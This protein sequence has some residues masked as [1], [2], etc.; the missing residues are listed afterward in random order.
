MQDYQTHYESLQAARQWGFNISNF[1]ALCKTT[2][3]IF[4]FIDYWDVKRHEL[5]FAIDGIVLKVNSYAQQQ[6]LGFT[7]KSPKWAIAYKFKAEEVETE[8]Q[9][10]DFQVGRHGTITPV[11][12]LAPVQLAGTTVKRATLKCS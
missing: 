11:A 7:A 8:L 10:V 3:E 4:E 9:S 6:A 5:P 12:N 1:M 2:E